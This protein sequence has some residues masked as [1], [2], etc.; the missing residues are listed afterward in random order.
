MFCPNCHAFMNESHLI[1]SNAKVMSDV[2]VEY[3]AVCPN[4]KVHI[5]RMFWGE[6][7]LAPGLTAYEPFR[8][9]QEQMETDEPEPAGEEPATEEEPFFEDFASEEERFAEDESI[10]SP[11]R[12]SYFCPHCGKILPDDL[13]QLPTM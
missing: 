11:T 5:G 1:K 6:L 7:R 10:P 9:K 12:R 8:L 3:D 2:A 13:S 4:C